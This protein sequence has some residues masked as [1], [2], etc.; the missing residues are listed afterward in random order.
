M[1]PDRVFLPHPEEKMDFENP[2][3]TICETLRLAYK[4][5]NNND[6]EDAKLKIRIAITMAKSMS[7][8]LTEYNKNYANDFF[9]KK[10]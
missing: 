1:K 7:K 4:S 10:T 5:I 2:T 3:N 9:S 6:M 8:K